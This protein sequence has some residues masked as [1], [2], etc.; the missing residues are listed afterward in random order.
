MLPE[1]PRRNADATLVQKPMRPRRS[2]ASASAG[3]R[4]AQLGRAQLHLHPEKMWTFPWHSTVKMSPS[5]SFGS[6]VVREQV[7]RSVAAPTAGTNGPSIRER[8]R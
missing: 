8:L 6:E 7:A 1:M 2:V 5:I 3:V 4:P